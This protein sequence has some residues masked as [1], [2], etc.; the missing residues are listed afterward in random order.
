MVYARRR[1]V[2]L[3][4][5]ASRGIG[6]AVAEALAPEWHVLVGGTTA[7][8][9]TAVVDALPSA[10]P[11]VA[12]LTDDAQT[13]A[14]VSGV[15]GL[16]AIVHCAGIATL[17]SVRELSRDDWRRQFELNV[18]AVA[19][20]TRRLLPHLRPPYGQVV[21]INSGAGFRSGAGGGS[22]AA[23]KFALRAF[24]DALREEERGRVRVT[25]IHP[26]RVDTDMQVQLMTA[27]ARPYNP[28]E[29]LRPESVAAAV[30]FA[31]DATDDAMIEEIVVRPAR[32]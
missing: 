6:R 9:V 7:E 23:T 26:G 28:A 31:L 5:G 27:R 13:A 32:G 17:G 2:V 10:Q 16:D 3:V 21:T 14:A 29:H 15:N 24:T 11:F 22:Y 1:L 25:S 20:L 19:D 4:T 12:D 8:G 18:V 30:K